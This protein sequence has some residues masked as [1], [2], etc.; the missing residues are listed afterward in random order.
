MDLLRYLSERRLTERAL[1]FVISQLFFNAE[2]PDN[3]KYA[4][5]AGY[6]INAVDSSGNNAIFGC[7]TQEALDFL[8]SNEVNIHH[9]NKEGQNA[10]FHQK[11]PEILKK[12]IELGLDTSHTDTKG[13]TCIFAHYMDPEGL[14][15]LINAGCDINHVDNSGRN[16][17][18]LPL[19]PEVLSIAIDAGCNVNQI[20]HEGK[21]FIE[22]EYDDE[23]HNIILRHIDKFERRTLHVDFCNTNSAL[24]LYKL[25]EYGFRIELNKNRFVINSYISDYRN[26][27]STLYCISD[28]QD[29]N[30]Y[31]Y[32]G[33]PLYKDIDKRIVKWMIRN[34]FLIDLTKISDD[35][36][37]N[38]ILKYKTSYEHKE[39]CRHLKPAKGKSPI[40]QNGGRL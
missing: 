34:E 38:D 11:N 16:I 13:Y 32:D 6:D 8:L 39:I 27:L 21:G 2:S 26:I 18:F 37:Y 31:N 9:I 22:E 25:S 12:L 1:D 20:N 17:L 7:R 33:G 24:F 5:K 4:L 15:V 19:S 10:L 14:Q 28:I 29:V 23:L 35:K 40:I 36:N 30:F 3:L